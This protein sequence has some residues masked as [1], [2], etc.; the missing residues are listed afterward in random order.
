[1][2]AKKPYLEHKTTAY[3]VPYRIRTEE[4]LWL[5]KLYLWLDGQAREETLLYRVYPL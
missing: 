1:M 2:N 5:R 4:A 3:K